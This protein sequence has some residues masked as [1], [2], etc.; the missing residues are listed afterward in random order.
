MHVARQPVQDR[1]RPFDPS[2]TPA[3]D[4]AREV[5]AAFLQML[6]CAETRQ[7]ARRGTDQSRYVAMASALV[8]DL[9]HLTLTLPGASL[10]VS[11]QKAFYASERRPADFL[12]EGF[13][14]MVKRLSGFPNVLEVRLGFQGHGLGL[15]RR[16]TVRP[17]TALLELFAE[18]RISLGDIGR[19]SELQGDCLVLKAP[20]VKGKSSYLPIPDN[21]LTRRLRSEVQSINAWIASAD[22]LWQEY[23]GE[24]AVDA[25][26][27][28]LRRVFNNGSFEAGGRLFGGFWHRKDRVDRIFFG[29]ECAVGLDYGQMGVRCAYALAGAEPPQGDLYAVP[30]LERHRDGVKKVLSALLAADRIPTRF[31]K[32][33]RTEG[34]FPRSWKM[35]DVFDPIA[36]HHSAIRHLFGSSLCYRQMYEESCLVVEILLRLKEQG[37]VALPVHDGL[38]VGEDHV[39]LAEDA[40]R[41]VFK[42]RIGLEAVVDV[43]YPSIFLSNSISTPDSP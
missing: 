4:T 37:V 12:T 8:L 5:V 35:E 17:G 9:A 21:D 29:E 3:T 16:T 22:L 2:K 24:A 28:F 7:R 27:R 26:D 43:V 1:D 41:E 25:G 33:I 20:K 31:P 38:V 14:D 10:A 18:K 42:N 34:L 6:A 13:I 40:M 19:N 23:E 32:G 36:N 11:L 15:G 30:G 39:Q